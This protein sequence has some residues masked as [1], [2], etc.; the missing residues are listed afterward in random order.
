MSSSKHSPLSCLVSSE[1]ESA[2]NPS[3]SA[4]PAR[5]FATALSRSEA[6]WK[7]TRQRAQIGTVLTRD[8][9]SFCEIW[10]KGTKPESSPR[11]ADFPLM[12]R[13]LPVP[14][15]SSI[16]R[17][18]SALVGRHT[19]KNSVCPPPLQS[20]SG[21]SPSSVPRGPLSSPG[22][23]KVA[24]IVLGSCCKRL[25]THSRLF[26]DFSADIILLA[27]EA[28]AEDPALL[29]LRLPERLDAAE[30]GKLEQPSLE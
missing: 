17:M 8:L 19:E 7:K 25:R 26:L 10:R 29:G 15:P 30:L 13:P 14:R 16:T 3:I 2:T 4:R 20:I 27:R 12:L 5:S 1:V 21:S 18:A 28:E 23:K 22:W 9:W 11:F 24:I 6:L